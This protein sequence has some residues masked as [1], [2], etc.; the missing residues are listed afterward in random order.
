MN[1]PQNIL[2]KRKKT[3]SH[4]NASFLVYYFIYLKHDITFCVVFVLDSQSEW[5]HSLGLVLY[6]CLNNGS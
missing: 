2:Q 5:L 4:L 3:V 6:Y 1:C